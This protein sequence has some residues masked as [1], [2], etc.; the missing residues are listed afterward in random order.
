M[1]NTI[2]GLDGNDTI[3]A[4]TGKTNDI[5]DGGIGMDTISY[6]QAT[7]LVTIDLSNTS[8]QVTTGSGSDTITGFENLTGSKYNDTLNGDSNSNIILGGAGND[9]INSNGGNDTLDGGAGNDIFIFDQVLSIDNIDTILNFSSVYDTIKIDDSIFDVFTNLGTILQG[10]LFSSIDGSAS[11]GDDYILYN[12]TTG[13]LS[14]DNDGSGSSAALVFATLG[15]T[16]HPTISY[17]D[18]IVI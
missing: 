5:L 4:G 15:T 2:N 6:E 7:S 11:D 13:E 12:T 1:S 16:L 9:T 3:I 14:Y 8:S 10:N 17:T 18:F